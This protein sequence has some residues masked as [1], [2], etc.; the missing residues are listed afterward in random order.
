MLSHKERLN[1]ELDALLARLAQTPECIEIEAFLASHPDVE[2]GFL[3]LFKINYARHIHSVRIMRGK[4]A[5]SNVR[6]VDFQPEGPPE[7]VR[8]KH[9]LQN[10]KEEAPG[11]FTNMAQEMLR[12]GWDLQRRMPQTL[13]E[14]QMFMADMA[15]GKGWSEG[16]RKRLEAAGHEYIRWLMKRAAG[17]GGAKHGA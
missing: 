1:A 6:P 7:I 14:E 4:A 3:A 16:H 17:N 2:L 5:R 9:L 8:A 13:E 12:S 11:A 15:A 10:V